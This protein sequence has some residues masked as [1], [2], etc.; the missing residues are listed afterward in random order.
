VK[1]GATPSTAAAE[2]VD[3][4]EALRKALADLEQF[5]LHLPEAFVEVGFPSFQVT[6]MNQVA[7]ALLGYTAE[8]IAAGIHGYSL[9]DERSLVEVLDAATKHLAGSTW[10]GKPYEREPG[11]RVFQLTLIRKDGSRFPADVQGSY[12]LDD[13][14]TPVGVRYIF[15]DTTLRQLAELERARLAAIVESSDDAIIS[16]TLDGVVLSWN[17]AAERMY[18]YTAAEMVGSTLK[19]I[20]VPGG[21]VLRQALE[22]DGRIE[23]ATIETRRRRKDRS[24][25]EVS[26]SI[27]PVRDARGEVFAVGNIERDI[28]ERIRALNEIRR[29][30]ELI[31]A[32][33]SA[34]TLFIRERDAR[35]VFQALLSSLLRL[36]GSRYGFIG[37]VLY[38]DGMPYL[39]TCALTD[40]SWDEA[41]REL[42]QR[43]LEDG[44]EFTNPETLI[45]RVITTG[46]PV[47]SN[48]PKSDPRRGAGPDRQ[49][50]L[51]SFLG[52]PIRVG[53]ET[54]G[55]VGIANREGGYDESIARF[56]E[57]LLTTCGSIFEA[58]KTE[59]AR[60]EAEDRLERAMRGG[61][62][63]LWEWDIQAGQLSAHFAAAGARGLAPD[64][65]KDIASFSARVHP[66][67]R[68]AVEDAFR[69]HAEGR[70][71]LID[72]EHRALNGAGKYRWMLTRGMVVSR[73]PDGR[74][75]RAAGTFLDI[76][77]RKLAEEERLRLEQ[78]V[79]QSQKL[80]S[81]GVF[82]GGIAHDFNNLLTAILGN[83]YLLSQ[84]VDGP[85]RELA[86]EAREAAERGADVVRRLLAFARP[87]VERRETIDLD[88]LITETVKLA[89]S[90]LTPQVH[91]KVHSGN[92]A[93][94]SVTGSWTSLQQ[95]LMNLMVNA[96]DAMPAGGTITVSRRL[97]TVGPRHRWAPPELAR[98]KYHV[99]A[100]SDTGDGMPPEVV[101][102]IFDP[103]FTTKDIGRGSGLGLSTALGIARAHGGWLAVE[104]TPGEGSTFRLL[105]PAA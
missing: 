47:I 26:V 98:G 51:D 13:A 65:P 38:R 54:I 49:P 21:A 24:T 78:Q 52:L 41:S 55:M 58:S 68:A 28:G 67:D 33:S 105:L 14:G 70:Y 10:I 84:R 36:T 39:K 87:E 60:R 83:L 29:S 27:F 86:L 50:P 103:F 23:P 32:L 45:G 42:Y 77:E 35:T 20:E 69:G 63:A 3:L 18:G 99:I 95:V 17:S 59:A 46:E 62:L 5:R 89:R 37:Q 61:E 8:D 81:L 31:E 80:E 19:R 57:P 93:S 101:A 92:P 44:L 4:H 30:S 104:S 15:R 34:Q 102:R 66:D 91:V 96:R 25:V 82:A 88:R 11:Q 71:P 7:R 9:L 53:E 1:T 94:A 75:L 72:C 22:R 73:A 48:D 97:V 76:T 56:L 6:Y 100:I 85:E 12:I 79:R 2:E 74:P 43:H 16:R 90:V 64:A 40:I